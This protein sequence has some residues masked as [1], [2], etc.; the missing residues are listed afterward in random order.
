MHF[1]SQLKINGLLLE[2]QGYFQSKMNV[3]EI[4]CKEMIPLFKN[5]KYE[6]V[7]VE[8]FV[9]MD[10]DKT[11]YSDHSNLV[12]SEVSHNQIKLLHI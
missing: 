11:V 4:H 9:L 1:F 2:V 6:E 8:E 10:N 7:V 12:I 3:L 5:L